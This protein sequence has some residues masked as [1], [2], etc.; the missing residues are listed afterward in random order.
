MNISPSPHVAGEY[1]VK[2]IMYGV[3][4]AL[5]PTLAASVYYFGIGAIIVTLVAVISSVTF[6]FLI[7]KYLLKGEP[8]IFDG[9]A[10]LT[11][12]LLAFNV[13]SNLPIGIIII[14]ALIAIGVG[15]MSFG[16]LGQNPFNP[17]LVGRVF[18]LISFPVQ[19]TS[20]PLPKGFATGYADAV[21]GATPLG[22][23]K[24]GIKNNHS[25]SDLMSN[26][27]SYID[28]LFGHMGGSMGEVSAIALLL[29]FAYMLYKKII[30]WHIPVY[31]IGTVFVFSAILHLA[32]PEKFV[33]P[34][35]NI[36]TGGVMLGAIFMATDMVTSPMTPKGMAI[37]AIG[38]AVLTV[39]IRAFGAYPEGVSFAILIMNAFVPIINKYV[40]PK[41]FGEEVKNG[42]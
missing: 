32:S 15:K 38:I 4:M 12:L 27:P 17:A 41:R 19:M 22:I 16:G 29:G 9:S 8:T 24:E 31:M 28:Q 5:M 33:D 18:L 36:L 34:V 21:T 13:P 30:T 10:I 2:K 7:Q 42:K 1:S 6:E 26:V 40:K 35:F 39:L 3:I 14:G 11:G 25:L 23:I 20:W 37:F